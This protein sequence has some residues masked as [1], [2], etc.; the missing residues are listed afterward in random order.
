VRQS[1]PSVPS[2]RVQELRERRQNLSEQRE[3]STSSDSDVQP[4]AAR[5]RALAEYDAA[6]AESDANR[7]RQLEDNRLNARTINENIDEQARS[8]REQRS[9]LVDSDR[10]DERHADDCKK[11]VRLNDDDK[12]NAHRNSNDDR[13]DECDS[14]DRPIDDYNKVIEPNNES[15]YRPCRFD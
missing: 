3:Y 15:R 8:R 13:K 12:R 7:Q 5:L 14:G 1:T 11:R 2:R 10:K 4:S 9:V 6:L